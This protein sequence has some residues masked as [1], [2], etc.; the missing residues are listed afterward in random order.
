MKKN[1]IK[2]VIIVFL[3][4]FLFAGLAGCENAEQVTL[5]NKGYLYLGF[6]VPQSGPLSQIGESA[7]RGAQL[8]VDAANAAGGV[9]GRPVKLRLEDEAR[10]VNEPVSRRLA[11]DP[12]VL[13]I[14]GHLME[15]TFEAGRPDYIEAGL[16]VLV[17][18]LSGDDVS[19]SGQGQFFRLMTS[20]SAQTRALADYAVSGMKSGRI[21]V[22]HEETDFSRGLAQT[23]VHAVNQTNTSN[24]ETMVYSNPKEN[25]STLIN[26]VK[27]KKPETVFLA[28]DGLQA[29]SLAKTM[30]DQKIRAVILGTHA[31][32]FSDVV[33]FL[34]NNSSPVF[35]SLPFDYKNAD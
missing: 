24:V 10:I 29:I 35:L 2:R 25:I 3:L 27:S 30:S 17:P 14:I 26:Q 1:V 8:A 21:L 22:I 12:R 23:F 5:E 31:L 32:A 19:V 33:C 7:I 20:D 9:Q 13:M 16:P 34:E 6:I 4:V 28:L 18:F 15:R 11:R